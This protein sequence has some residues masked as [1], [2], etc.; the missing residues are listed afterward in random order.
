MTAKYAYL[1]PIAMFFSSAAVYLSTYITIDLSRDLLLE[2]WNSVYIS[3]K[4][5]AKNFKFGMPIDH[6]GL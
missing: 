6:N 5:E 3:E 4:V 2:F 1:V